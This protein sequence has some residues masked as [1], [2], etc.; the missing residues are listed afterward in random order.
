MKLMKVLH[1]QQCLFEV[2]YFI[3]THGIRG[4]ITSIRGTK[5]TPER[6]I[7]SD[8]YISELGT[9]HFNTKSSF[10]ANLHYALA[11]DYLKKTLIDIA[12]NEN[13]FRESVVLNFA[14]AIKEW[15]RIMYPA[16]YKCEIEDANNIDS[17]RFLVDRTLKYD[18]EMTPVYETLKKIEIQSCESEYEETALWLMEQ[19]NELYGDDELSPVN[20]AKTVK[21]LIDK[22]V[23]ELFNS[24]AKYLNE[25]EDK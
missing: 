9:F 25:K 12:L 17:L 23:K 24:Y 19:F 6:N 20:R 21:E 11:F 15:Q 7:N 13:V 1:K 2:F 16:N 10:S 18:F 4:Q 5:R 8:F 14:T 22:E 3:E